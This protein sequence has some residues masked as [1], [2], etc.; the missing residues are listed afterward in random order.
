LQTGL[1]EPSSFVVTSLPF[2]LMQAL[3]KDRATGGS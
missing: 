1:R 2:C 3:Y